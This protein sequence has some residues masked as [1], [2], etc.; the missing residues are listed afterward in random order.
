VYYVVSFYQFLNV[1]A[2][3]IYIIV[4]RNNILSVAKPEIDANR[5][6]KTT[7]LFSLALL[8]CILVVSYALR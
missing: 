3:S 6:S 7:L 8:G 2:F 5:L 4:I 1:A